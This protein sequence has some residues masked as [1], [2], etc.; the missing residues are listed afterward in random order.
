ME[1]NPE[2][3]GFAATAEHLFKEPWSPEK[4]VETPFGLADFKR[5]ATSFE[6]AVQE[7]KDKYG[8]WDIAWGDVHRARIG[9]KDLPVGGCT[10][11]LGCFRVLWYI[12]HQTDGNKLEVRGGDGWVF[13][14]EFPKRG[15][16]ENPRAYSVLAYGQS[17][18]E[19]SPHFN[20]QLDLFTNNKM[21]QVVFSE[22]DILDQLEREYHPGLE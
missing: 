20:D 1:A 7:T 13:A 16:G 11:L 12:P 10:G 5:A 17:S 14:V 6:W 18:K 8:S 21:K 19:D 4:P 15:S 22:E 3:A 9:E 2:A